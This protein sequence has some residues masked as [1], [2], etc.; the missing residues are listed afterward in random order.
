M[1]AHRPSSRPPVSD[2]S[3][4]R[5]LCLVSLEIARTIPLLRQAC[6]ALLISPRLIHV[7]EAAT[8]CPHYRGKIIV[9]QSASACERARATI[10][11]IARR[12]GISRCCSVTDDRETTYLHGHDPVETLEG[13]QP[14]Y[15]TPSEAVRDTSWVSVLPERPYGCGLAIR[16]ASAVACRRRGQSPPQPDCCRGCRHWSIITP[17][18]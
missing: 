7:S 15:F 2:N 5:R 12:S 14:R 13:R 4:S 18:M 17:T 9:L 11:P 6:Q 8:E 3:L 10:A 16:A 1:N